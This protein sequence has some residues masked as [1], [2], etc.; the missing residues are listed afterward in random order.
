MHF[1]E[2]V[3]SLPSVRGDICSKA[4]HKQYVLKPLIWERVQ[5]SGS[6]SLNP[7]IIQTRGRPGPHK[8]LRELCTAH[9]SICRREPALR[10][11]DGWRQNRLGFPGI[12]SEHAGCRAVMVNATSLRAVHDAR[13]T[14]KLYCNH[15][16]PQPLAS[17][18]CLCS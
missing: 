17:H 18:F 16:G 12:L 3:F 10:S 1:T 13:G 4:S 14:R 2:R 9:F 5:D 15:R 7:L 11:F 8:C 6:A